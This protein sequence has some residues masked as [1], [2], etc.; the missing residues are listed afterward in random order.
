MRYIPRYLLPERN[1]HCD[2]NKVKKEYV[3]LL[4]NL[5]LQLEEEED[6]EQED[7]FDIYVSVKDPEKIGEVYYWYLFLT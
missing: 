1:S 7:Q 6:E 3:H 2:C 4:F 5:L